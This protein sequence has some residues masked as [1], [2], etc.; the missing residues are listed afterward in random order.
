MAA[1]N[2]EE[3]AQLLKQR[4]VVKER[5]TAAQVETAKHLAELATLERKLFEHDAQAA[6]DV[7][8]W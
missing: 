7:L 2:N 6:A 4:A 5:L 3:L 1:G 8:C